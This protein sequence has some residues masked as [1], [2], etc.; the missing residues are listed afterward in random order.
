MAEKDRSLAEFVDGF[1]KTI[2]N[3]VNTSE[4][5]GNCEGFKCFIYSNKL[6][7]LGFFF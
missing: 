6:I 3:K 7:K 4:N 1:T 2:L 5:I